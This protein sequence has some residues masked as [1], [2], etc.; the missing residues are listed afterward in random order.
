[1]REKVIALLNEMHPEIVT[2][3]GESILKEGLVDSFELISIVETLEDAF[4]V[5]IDADYVTDENFGTLEKMVRLL[6]TLLE[7]GNDV[8]II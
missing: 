2:F 1:M 6:E 4:D 5:E 8:S 3:T 7:G